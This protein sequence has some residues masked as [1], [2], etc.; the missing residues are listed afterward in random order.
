M[1]FNESQSPRFAQAVARLHDVK[2]N[3]APQITPEINHGVTL[4]QVSFGYEF[5]ALVSRRNIFVG[6]TGQAQGA[7]ISSGVVIQPP[8]G[9]NSTILVVTGVQV[10]KATAG[11]VQCQVADGSFGGTFAPSFTFFRDRRFG[12]FA[13]ARP[14]TRAFTHLTGGLP[15]GNTVKR[16]QVL[17]GVW[18]QIP[19]TPGLVIVNP[20]T[21]N[22]AGFG[23]FN[24]TLNEALDVMIDCY[25]R[26]ISVSELNLPQ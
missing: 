12:A 22:F 9:N 11:F 16:V 10:N 13:S 4:E 15:T 20:D 8:T 19:I 21:T 3:P 5:E 24:E 2:G 7:G 18:T 14:S 26:A 6:I 1:A 23:V 17:A 25:E